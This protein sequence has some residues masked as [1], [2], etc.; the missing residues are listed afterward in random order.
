MSKFVKALAL[1]FNPTGLRALWH[2]LE[3]T[4]EASRDKELSK[5]ESD[6]IGEAVWDVVEAYQKR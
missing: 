6:E 5:E 3:L 4:R 2:L 1:V